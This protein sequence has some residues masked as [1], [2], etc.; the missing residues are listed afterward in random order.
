MA[1]KA[2]AKLITRGTVV[3]RVPGGVLVHM[4]ISMKRHTYGTDPLTY[5][6]ICGKCVAMNRQ[7]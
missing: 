2:A 6:S 1:P 4:K 3:P 7:P 5:E